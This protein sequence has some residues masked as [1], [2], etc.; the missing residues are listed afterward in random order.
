MEIIKRLHKLTVVIACMI[1]LVSC[2]ETYEKKGKSYRYNSNSF[3]DIYNLYEDGT[4]KRVY[5][6]KDSSNE[7]ITLE[8]GTYTTNSSSIIF[9]VEQYE[10]HPYGAYS[11][12]YRSY[13]GTLESSLY[14]GDYYNSRVYK[15]SGEVYSCGSL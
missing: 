9:Y 8:E 10:G 14:L 6:Y 11:Y 7:K 13:S 2:C 12:G 4:Y 1:C 3:A 15:K 5:K